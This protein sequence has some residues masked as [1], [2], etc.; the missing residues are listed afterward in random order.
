MSLSVPRGSILALLG[1]SG[2]GK[3]TVL[4]AIAGFVQ[5]D[6]GIVR[7]HGRDVTGLAPEARNT[8]MVFQSYALFPHM[9]VAENVAFGLRMRRVERQDRTRRVADALALV[10]LDGF[11]ARYPSELSGG[12]QQRAA[13]ARA[14]VTRPD[15]LL[16]DEPFG[17]LDQNLR[18][19][20]Q[21]ELRK[22]QQELGL[23]TVIV[24]HDQQEAMI[25]ADRIA[26]LRAGSVEQVASPAALYDHPSSRF[27][28]AFMG[29]D[30]I[31]E[32]RLEGGGLRLGR[33]L[34]DMPPAPGG[35]PA[36]PAV[37]VAI[38]AEAVAIAP[39]DDPKLPHGRIGYVTNLGSRALYEIDVEGLGMLKVAEP[40][41]SGRPARQVG[42]CAGIR[43]DA[44]SCTVLRD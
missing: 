37:A 13:L 8:A 23:A 36:G 22:L 5:L 15:L 29:V 16:L 6:G 4:R 3:T 38:R 19:T 26:V 9:T 25:L 42:D 20:M 14:V 44:R 41:A 30:N 11:A 17:A 10:R 35:L 40:R 33:H 43:L 32:G 34:L 28:A 18:E 2:C 39:L 31:V 27:V 12:Q 24:T 7:L 21:I 1:P